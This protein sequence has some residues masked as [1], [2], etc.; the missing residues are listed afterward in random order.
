[1]ATF[2]KIVT[3]VVMVG[4]IMASGQALAGKGHGP[5]DGTGNGG[6]GPKD[7]TGYGSKGK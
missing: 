1:M 4:V 3:L 6:S 7:C 5:G 2:K